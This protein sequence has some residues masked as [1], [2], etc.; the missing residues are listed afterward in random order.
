[1]KKITILV[2]KVFLTLYVKIDNLIFQV[3]IKVGEIQEI[4]D[5]NSTGL[6]AKWLLPSLVLLIFSTMTLVIVD[7]VLQ[8]STIEYS[9]NKKYAQRMGMISLDETEMEVE[10][11][12]STQIYAEIIIDSLNAQ[13]LREQEIQTIIMEAET[14][15]LEAW[16]IDYIDAY[17]EANRLIDS[18][19]PLTSKR[20]PEQRT[21]P[22]PARSPAPV[23][24]KTRPPVIGGNSTSKMNVGLS[25]VVAIPSPP[26]TV[27][28]PK[29]QAPAQ[30]PTPIATPTKSVEE[31]RR[32]N[33]VVIVTTSLGA[34][35]VFPDNYF[36]YGRNNLTGRPK[37]ELTEMFLRVYKSAEGYSTQDLR[38]GLMYWY[39][40]DFINLVATK[41]RLPA[42]VI[43]AMFRIEGFRANFSET[44]LLCLNNNPGGIKHRAGMEGRIVHFKD[45]C[46][47]TDGEIILCQFAGYDTPEDGAEN[48]AK[49]INADRYDDAKAAARRGEPYAVVF[50]HFKNGGYWTAS[51]SAPINARA[52]YARAYDEFIK[53][54]K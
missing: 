40:Q 46:Y 6:A 52:K 34:T 43:A 32:E 14:Q 33:E 13:N 31:Q 48:W 19:K 39:Y 41:T 23:A 26:I 47:N 11:I 37:E 53:L 2:T 45:D 7:Y 25:P 44:D 51:G 17:Q 27:T 3:K 29:V 35:S 1:M 42:A 30:Q 54:R 28:A 4:I 24:V 16:V 21:A 22:P 20:L 15:A 36:Y 49:I 18:A 9:V 38:L 5:K 12:D 50:R 8:P 10:S